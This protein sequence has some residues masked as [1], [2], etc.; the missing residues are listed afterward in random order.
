[1]A[2]DGYRYRSLFW[3]VVLIGVGT[4]WLLANLNV[5]PA[6]GLWI[7]ARFWPLL[8]IWIGLD[9]LFGHRSPLLG[10]AIGVLAVGVAVLLVVGGPSWG[11]NSVGAGGELRT[12]RFIQQKGSATTAEVVLDLSHAPT[13]IRQAAEPA[14]LIDATISHRGQVDFT[15]SGDVKKRVNL[16]YTGTGGGWFWNWGPVGGDETW[17]IALG[18]GVPT[19]LVLDLSSG[20]TQGDLTGVRLQSLTVKAS[21]G[22]V[23]LR[24]PP[25]NGRPY[26]VM[27]DASS[28]SAR[29]DVSDGA[30]LEMGVDMSSGSYTLNLGRDVDAAITINGSSGR[31]S[32]DVPD[33]AALRLEVRDSSSGSVKVPSGM[34]EV[35]RGRDDEGV[36]QTPGFDGAQHQ[37]VVVV[38]QMS[39]GSIVVD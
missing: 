1:M 27:W 8:L 37:I 23:E 33:G 13:N 18:G 20:R 5:I 28:G 22:S 17:D 6:G 36:W 7:L 3:P 10:A 2:R 34:V 16:S 32:V 29:V 31:F 30:A 39:S 4:I 19:D 12:E 11:W 35:Q 9:I 38:E 21:S 15:V 25:S 14:T 26:P 24:L